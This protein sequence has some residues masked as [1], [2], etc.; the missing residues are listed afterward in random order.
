MCVETGVAEGS[1]CATDWPWVTGDEQAAA[2]LWKGID[3]FSFPAGI[4]SCINRTA[5]YDLAIAGNCYHLS[6]T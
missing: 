5:S 1:V 4:A 2:S 3:V 6:I